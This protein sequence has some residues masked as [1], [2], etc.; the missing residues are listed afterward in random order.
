VHPKR[1]LYAGLSLL[2]LLNAAYPAF[3]QTSLNAENIKVDNGSTLNISQTLGLSAAEQKALS[4][5]YK[6]SQK[7]L[8]GIMGILNS[9]ISKVS[10][11]I[12]AKFAASYKQ[13]ADLQKT[14]AE[15]QL[16]INTLNHTISELST[17]L[18]G[19]TEKINEQLK[20]EK[21]K[22]IAQDSK[23]IAADVN[24]VASLDSGNVTNTMHH[25][26]HRNPTDDYKIRAQKIATSIFPGDDPDVRNQNLDFI[27][28]AFQQKGL[29]DIQLLTA[30]LAT[31]RVECGR[32]IPIS[33]HPSKYN[34]IP[35]GQPFSL[36][37][38]KKGIGNNGIGE[39]ARF[40]GR[41]YLQLTG[42]ANYQIFS[43][44]IGLG[45]ELVNNPEKMND[46]DIAAKILVEFVYEHKDKMLA[47]IQ[48]QNYNQLLRII[49][50]GIFGL[51]TFQRSFSNAESQIEKKPD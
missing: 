24:K 6:L 9:K 13:I 34:T 20:P 35:G 25:S 31:I 29:Q 2:L 51:D 3:S 14:V 49:N 7:Q 46:P 16:T 21:E 19:L 18:Y 47:A 23:T 1:G 48:A 27:L 42:R 5:Q 43:N 30:T 38:F 26:Y 4:N 28:K 32:L 40:K 17:M 45:D 50:G 22:E 11:L 33:E 10:E 37:D 15:L 8:M 44:K 41:G 39:G 36:Y 12:N